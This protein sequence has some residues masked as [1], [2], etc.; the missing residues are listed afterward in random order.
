MTEVRIKENE[1][2]NKR[3]TNVPQPRQVPHAPERQGQK[4]D[5][6]D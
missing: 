2:I 1:D 5:K 6:K 3:G 4:T